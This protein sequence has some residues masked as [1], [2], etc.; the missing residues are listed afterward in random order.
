VPDGLG[1]GLD[2]F[3]GGE[4]DHGAV[5]DPEAALHLDREIDVPRRVDDVDLV[6]S[7][8]AGRHGGGDG[9]PPLPLL[10]DPVH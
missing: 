2:P 5:E 10:G 6:V 9:D 4:D 1:L 8:V 7:P 3:H